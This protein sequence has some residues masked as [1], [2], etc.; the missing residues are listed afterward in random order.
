MC[1][2]HSF[3][4]SDLLIRLFC[5][6]FH[7][8]LLI[9]LYTLLFAHL[10][11]FT[12]GYQLRHFFILTGTTSKPRPFLTGLFFGSYIL[13]TS[14]VIMSLFVGVI[15]MGMFQAFLEYK[16]KGAFSAYL[17]KLD[18]NS[19]SEE[20]LNAMGQTSLK[21]KM[22]MVLNPEPPKQCYV[23]PSVHRRRYFKYVQNAQKIRDSSHFSLLITVTIIA[24]GV[25]IGFDTDAS[26][27][28]FRLEDR[29]D[30]RDD[31]GSDHYK[32]AALD[33]CSH[34][35][36]YSVAITW[37]AQAIF[38]MEM[39]VKV[40]AEGT[41]PLRYFTDKENGSWNCM[42]CFI[43]VV[44]FL[45][46]SALKDI[47]QFFPIVLLRLLRLVRVFRL[48]KALPRLRSIVEALVSGFSSVGW[49]CLLI[50]VFNYIV[51]CMF[52]LIFKNNVRKHLLIYAHFSLPCV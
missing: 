37:T 2:P 52:M 51:A 30:A 5:E 23:H 21:Q 34:D 45:E 19:L 48:A 18:E 12:I 22:D 13:L 4:L 46:S 40:F 33:R 7:I 38:T 15:S 16:E 41:K 29:A 20:E 25:V 42:D 36:V 14:W 8:S 47:F 44:G 31:D 24:V 35:A 27:R 3:D 28:C 10:T 43:V 49:I 9:I 17:N 26:L 39:F 50:L 32:E 1:V 6:A 11:S